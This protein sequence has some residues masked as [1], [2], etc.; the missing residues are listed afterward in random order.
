MVI[1]GAS[2]HARVVA[3]I[4]QTQGV[5]DI[6][7]FIDDV[8]PAHKGVPFMGS[9]ILGGREKFPGLLQV[10]VDKAIVAIGDCA[11]RM[12]LA[13]D[14]RQAGFALVTAIHPSATIAPDVVISAGSVVA[15]GA[16]LNPGARV[17]ENAIINTS[18]SVDHDA[19]VED[20][21]HVSPGARLAGGVVVGRGSWIGMGA[22]VKEG[23]KIGRN[24]VV[25]AGAVVLDD[26]PDRVVAWGVPARVVK[27][28]ATQ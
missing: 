6:A 13:D 7:G 22:C 2:G 10:G 19:V 20:G 14:L 3:D 26:L 11:I 16:V 24:V 12:R 9:S 18:S 25:G 1:W 23:V 21:A 17:G 28:N 15:A 27:S 5:C 8:D 4:V